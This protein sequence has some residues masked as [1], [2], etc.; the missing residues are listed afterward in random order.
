MNSNNATTKNRDTKKI[1][2][3]MVLI[4]VFMISTTGATYAYFA[5]SASNSTA[6]GTAATVSLNLNVTRVT[7]TATKWTASTQVMVPQLDAGLATAMN[8]TNSCVDG[9]S[10]VICQVYKITI[11]N[12]STS[13]VR[14]R[15]AVYFSISGTF[16]NLYWRQTTNANTL[17]T[18]TIYK[19]STSEST[20]STAANA[21]NSTL[22]GDLL[23][24]KSDGT[25]GSGNDYAEYYV[26]I[27]IRETNTDQGSSASSTA[28]DQ[29]TWTMNVSFKDKANGSGVTSTITS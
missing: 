4:T 13:S 9:N 28:K 18:N 26:V 29:G 23:L 1:L 6:T 5:I 7:P 20:N 2:T 19:F 25:A 22:N 8:S 21:A 16:N 10:N 12:G 24:Q 27:W 15:G 14:L 17:G 3:L 11:E